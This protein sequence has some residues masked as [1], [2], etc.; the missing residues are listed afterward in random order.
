M[1][2]RDLAQMLLQNHFTAAGALS[3]LQMRH[4]PMKRRRESWTPCATARA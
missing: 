2:D 1:N 4:C 3:A